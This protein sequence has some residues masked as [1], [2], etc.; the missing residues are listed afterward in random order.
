ML[1]EAYGFI[2]SFAVSQGFDTVVSVA[3]HCSL[4]EG[5]KAMQL[6]PF[7]EVAKTD[8][9][10]F[11]STL[12]MRTEGPRNPYELYLENRFDILADYLEATDL[13]QE[14]IPDL[15]RLLRELEAVVGETSLLTAS[16][17]RGLLRNF[18]KRLEQLA[19][20]SS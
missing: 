11:I 6:K 3:V 9:G 10:G 12:R 4:T 7:H 19:A 1:G 13:P 20:T 17:A 2:F 15:I 14:V 18:E 16:N 8:I 5:S